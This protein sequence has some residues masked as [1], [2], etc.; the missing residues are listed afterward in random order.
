MLMDKVQYSFEADI[1]SL[2]VVIYVMLFG[3]APFKAGNDIQETY[4]KI[5]ECDYEIPYD[6]GY[7]NP[8][9]IDLL[10]RIFVINPR[11]RLSI[12]DIENHPFLNGPGII[13]K[14]L[15]P[16]FAVKAPS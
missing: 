16:L 2:G 10:S 3:E 5:I 8:M 13:P 11:H 4:K 7:V 9:A 14:K 15:S 12:H 1:W 6:R